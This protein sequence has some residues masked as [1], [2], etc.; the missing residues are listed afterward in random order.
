M[1]KINIPDVFDKQDDTILRML[2][3][4]VANRVVLKS[5]PRLDLRLGNPAAIM[6]LQQY[7]AEMFMLLVTQEELDLTQIEDSV[8]VTVPEKPR[9]VN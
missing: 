1:T 4:R 7:L 3:A 8:Q 9:V 6:L 2:I 5:D